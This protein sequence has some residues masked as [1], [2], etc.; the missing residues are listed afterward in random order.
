MALRNHFASLR[1]RLALLMF[2][3]TC[4][5]AAVGWLGAR[6]VQSALVQQKHA[7]LRSQVEVAISVINHEI[8]R[9]RKG[10]IGEADARRNAAEAL[11]PIRFAGQEY[12]CL[13]DM[14]GINVMH[15]I[16]KELEGKDLS[17]L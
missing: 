3:M 11:R 10:E 9:L 14:K 5:V 13:Y 2:A 15:P 1:M 12:F 8:N 16:R 6:E 17:G 4:M 7:E